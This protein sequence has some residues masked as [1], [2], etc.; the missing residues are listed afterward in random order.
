MHLFKV[1]NVRPEEVKKNYLEP[2][3]PH[4]KNIGIR[5][6]CNGKRSSDQK[7]HDEILSIVAILQKKFH[8][9]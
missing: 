9:I 5:F 3:F 8:V 6:A 4:L 7:M 2:Y 1:G